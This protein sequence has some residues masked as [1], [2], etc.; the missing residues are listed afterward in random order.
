VKYWLVVYRR[1]AG[2]LLR[3]EEFADS[4]EALDERFRLE[5]RAGSGPDLEIVVLSADSLDTVKKTHARYFAR[6]A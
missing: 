4:G 5:L 2:E 6:S 3:C 1:S